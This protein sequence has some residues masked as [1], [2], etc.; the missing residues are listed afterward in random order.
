VVP[1]LN[2]NM[3]LSDYLRNLRPDKI[4]RVPVP[5]WITTINAAETAGFYGGRAMSPFLFERV[6]AQDY[7]LYY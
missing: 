3:I 4:I 7:A 2:T 6:N 5:T 1:G